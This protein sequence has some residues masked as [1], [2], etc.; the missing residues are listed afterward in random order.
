MCFDANASHRRWANRKSLLLAVELVFFISIH[1]VMV[2]EERCRFYPVLLNGCATDGDS[3]T[4]RG[5]V[6]TVFS[7][8][9]RVRKLEDAVCGAVSE[10]AIKRWW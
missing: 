4:E 2:K 9:S 6:D 8:F 1:I 3:A 7:K 5:A 10:M